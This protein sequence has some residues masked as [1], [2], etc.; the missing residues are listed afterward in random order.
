[1]CVCVEGT[2]SVV[3]AWASLVASGKGCAD[4]CDISLVCLRLAAG[5]PSELG[6][7]VKRWI[8]KY[9]LQATGYSQ[10][11]TSPP[12]CFVDRIQVVRKATCWPRHANVTAPAN[13]ED[14]DACS[15]RRNSTASCSN[16]P[17]RHCDVGAS[18]KRP[19]ATHTPTSPWQQWRLFCFP[20]RW[21]SD[22]AAWELDL[23]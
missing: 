14:A 16:E 21:I 15:G 9:G 23:L 11:C 17:P 3:S 4:S 10:R 22:N 5:G 8:G 12:F 1:M 18:L 6:R 20:R 13:V 19:R 7:C 2:G